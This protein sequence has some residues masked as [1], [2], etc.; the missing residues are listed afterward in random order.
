MHGQSYDHSMLI[1]KEW[2]MLI[3]N[4]SF[5]FITLF[6]GK[7]ERIRLFE[8]GVKSKDVIRSSYYLSDK[9]VEKFQPELVGKSYKGKYIVVYRKPLIAEEFIDIFEILEI[10]EKSLKLKQLKGGAIFE[11]VLLKDKNK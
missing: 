7:E 3:P 11:Y 1:K 8:N 5:N 4:K 10:T 9:I 2:K 6:N